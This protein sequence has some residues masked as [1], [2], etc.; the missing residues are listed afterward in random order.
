MVISNF[1]IQN[2][3]KYITNK[4]YDKII[5]FNITRVKFDI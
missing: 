5:V 4:N 1:I 3:N 2:Y